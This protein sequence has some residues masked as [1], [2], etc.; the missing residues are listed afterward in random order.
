MTSK[1]PGYYYKTLKELDLNYYLI[2]NEYIY[3]LPQAKI[4]PNIF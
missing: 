4:H 3:Q 1:T 2:L